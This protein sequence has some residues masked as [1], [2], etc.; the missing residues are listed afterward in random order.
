MAKNQTVCQVGERRRD[1][2]VPEQ[3]DQALQLLL[4][5]GHRLLPLLPADEPRQQEQLVQGNLHRI[6][7]VLRDLQGYF[8][9][10]IFI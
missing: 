9:N 3:S 6:L 8:R 2:H 4:V 7:V 1:L 10:N 5:F